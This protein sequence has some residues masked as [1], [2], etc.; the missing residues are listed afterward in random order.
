MGW[1]GLQEIHGRPGSISF[2][3]SGNNP[4]L[5][6][7]GPIRDLFQYLAS[8]ETKHKLELKKIYSATVHRGGGV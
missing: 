8:E 5:A 2:T 7:A 4:S 6:P 3:E 1:L